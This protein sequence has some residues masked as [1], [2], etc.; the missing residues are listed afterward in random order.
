M[1]AGVHLRSLFGDIGPHWAMLEHGCRMV[2]YAAFP[3]FFGLGSEAGHIPTFWLLLEAKRHRTHRKGTY[4]PGTG[5]CQRAHRNVEQGGGIAWPG[6]RENRSSCTIAWVAVR[7]LKLEGCSKIS[8]LKL[9]DC[10]HMETE[11][12]LWFPRY[13]NVS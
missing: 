5:A 8:G 1:D 13:A 12:C 3:S 4:L 7:G 11:H 9:S 6:P 10:V 2:Y